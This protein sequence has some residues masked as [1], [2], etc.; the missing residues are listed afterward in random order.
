[1]SDVP[2]SRYVIGTQPVGRRAATGAW[3]MG[4]VPEVD[5]GCRLQLDDIS[6]RMPVANACGSW[7]QAVC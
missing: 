5:D 2:M 3:S 1:M 4:W 7:R 6:I